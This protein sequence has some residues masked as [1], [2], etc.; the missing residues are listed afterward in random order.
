VHLQSLLEDPEVSYRAP[1]HFSIDNRN[2]KGEGEWCSVCPVFAKTGLHN[3]CWQ[4]FIMEPNFRVL[5][6]CMQFW[7][8]MATL[9]RFFRF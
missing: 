6:N 9:I 3:S 4:W 8:L 2:G 7:D 1:W 5:S